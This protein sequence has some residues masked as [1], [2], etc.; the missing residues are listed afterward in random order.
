MD[1]PA[2]IG[3]K[4]WH[5]VV[6][7]RDP[8]LLPGCIAADAVF[9][10][11]AVHKPQEGRDMVAAYL[12]GALAVLGPEVI[13]HDE[14]ARDRDAVLRFT[15]TVDGREVEGI[16]LIRWDDDGLIV[17]FTVMIRPIRALEA[18][19][20]RMREELEKLAG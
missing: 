14:W 9:H 3:L 11:P 15:S 5:E 8:G 16:D 7:T 19:M 1:T 2:E 17:E 13:Y 20:A 6:E 10:S 18:V 12:T 4:R